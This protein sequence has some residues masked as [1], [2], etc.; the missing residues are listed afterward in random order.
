MSETVFVPP[1]QFTPP[2]TAGGNLNQSPN[3]NVAPST[4]R[5]RIMKSVA[6]SGKIKRATRSVINIRSKLVE[7]LRQNGLDLWTSAVEFEKTGDFILSSY[8]IYPKHNNYLE[9]LSDFLQRYPNLQAVCIAIRE[10]LRPEAANMQVS[11]PKLTD[12][13]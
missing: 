1:Q 2:S 9:K 3:F 7:Y 11:S 8:V 10:K 12:M 13:F 4:E 6:K 5:E